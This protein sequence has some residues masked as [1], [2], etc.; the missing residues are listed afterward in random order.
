ME[1]VQILGEDN[2]K[3]NVHLFEVENPKGYIQI[4]HGM[5]EHQERY[6]RLID[7]LNKVG[8]TVISSNIRGHGE[9]APMLGYFKEKNGYNY[10]ISDQ[11]NITKYI[12]KRYNTNKVIIIAHSMGTIIA[13]N[14][15]QTES[16]KYEKT[17]LIGYPCPQK[18]ANLGLILTNLIKLFKSPK[19]YSKLVEKMSVGKF[20]KQIKNAKTGVDWI[21]FNE[22]NVKEY[23]EDKYCGHIFTVSAFNDL[24]Y[25]VKNMANT[26]LY[27]NVNEK[28]PLLLLRGDSDPCTGYDK[29]S[30]ESISI[31]N[32][33]GFKNI[34]MIKYKHMRHEI[35]N[36]YNYKDVHKDI[37]EFL[38]L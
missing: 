4:I 6:E 27:K 9:D 13:R 16:N 30:Q 15:L 32:K 3:L 24:F 7:D 8:F 18:L 25:L 28:L 34:K 31:L 14:L 37:C 10:L 36:E 23:I 12:C 17:I 21:S 2:Y 38:L 19:Y 33:A 11:K 1:K 29:G 35:L 22:E 5:E 26:K 20:N